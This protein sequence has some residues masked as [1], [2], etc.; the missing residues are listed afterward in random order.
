MSRWIRGIYNA[1]ANFNM[2]GSLR[3]AAGRILDRDSKHVREE[4]NE[5]NKRGESDQSY[6]SIKHSELTT[7]S[8]SA[9]TCG[10]NCTGDCAGNSQSEYTTTIEYIGTDKDGN[11]KPVTLTITA[12]PTCSGTE[13]TYSA[14]REDACTGVRISDELG[15]IKQTNHGTTNPVEYSTGIPTGVTV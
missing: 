11:S 5:P 2:S 4:C 13:Y 12:K 10:S 15:T 8:T 9:R 6:K 7:T 1:A 3:A 14:T